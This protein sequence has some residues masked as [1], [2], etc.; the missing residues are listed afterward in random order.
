[1]ENNGVIK[2]QTRGKLITIFIPYIPATTWRRFM[3]NGLDSAIRDCIR[4]VSYTHLD[5]YKRQC[6]HRVFFQ[7]P[8]VCTVEKNARVTV[9]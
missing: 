9:S 4:S 8:R 2:T 7:T 6:D 1:M 3:A 5:V